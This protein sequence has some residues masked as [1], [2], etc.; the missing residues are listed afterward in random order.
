MLRL[1]ILSISPYLRYGADSANNQHKVF[2]PLL[3]QRRYHDLLCAEGLLR[4]HLRVEAELECQDYRG[5]FR[6]PAN[7]ANLAPSDT[8]PA[9]PLREAQSK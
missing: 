6:W 4:P 3:P 2:Q 7:T 9:T 1:L 5:A 8:G